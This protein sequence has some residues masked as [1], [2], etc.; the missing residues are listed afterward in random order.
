MFVA[1]HWVTVPA[2]DAATWLELLMG[3]PEEVNLELIFPGLLDE[4]D[5]DLVEDALFAEELDLPGLQRLALDVVA[6]AAGRPWW[7]TFRLLYLIQTHWSL[8]GARMLMSG[9]QA[10]QMSLSGWLDVAWV[11]V[12]DNVANDKWVSLAATLE[13][14]PVSEVENP[15]ATMEMSVDDFTAFMRG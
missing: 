12:F 10:E 3:E 8:L 7:L 15:M 9:V 1:G 13:T 4:A 6:E 2:Q 11:T 14:P 5:T